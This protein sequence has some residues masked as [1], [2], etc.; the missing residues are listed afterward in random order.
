ME[1]PTS[2]RLCLCRPG[3]VLRRAYGPRLCLY[4]PSQKR[5]K[6]PITAGRQQVQE[7]P[8]GA[9][10]ARQ[11]PSEQAATVASAAPLGPRVDR[12]PVT[13]ELAERDVVAQLPVRVVHVHV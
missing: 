10:R 9:A 13:D 3:R 12:V 7:A 1:R 6:L 11:A 2:P 4:R 5:S 8:P